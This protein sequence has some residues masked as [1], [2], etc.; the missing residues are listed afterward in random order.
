MRK[1]T[2]L[3]TGAGR[4]IGRAIARALAGENFHVI[5]HYGS[6]REGAEALADEIVDGGGSA[7]TLHADLAAPDA[8][9]RIAN[10][11][12]RLCGG[13]DVVVLNAGLMAPSGFA[14]CTV[15]TFDRLVAVNLRTPFFLL[16][17]LSPLLAEGASVVL[18]SSIT[19]HRAIGDVAAYAATKAGLESLVRRAAAELAPRWIRVNAVAPATIA[20]EGVRPFTDTEHGRRVTLA[21]QALQRI[22]QPEDVADV[23]AFLASD[24]ARWI[25]GAV[26]PVDGGTGL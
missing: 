7:D 23:V 5:L 21:M 1:R 22:G 14:N 9:E 12:A 18:V 25:D 20:S 13:L 4:G 2:A 19:A 15:E 10:E 11:V 24:K 3:V 6:S 17:H 26:I 8:A 16:Q